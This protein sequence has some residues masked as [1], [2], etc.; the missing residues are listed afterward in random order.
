V[1]AFRVALP[2][3]DQLGVLL[4]LN[5]LY[6]FFSC[7]NNMFSVLIGHTYSCHAIALFISFNFKERLF[8]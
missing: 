1:P 5:L 3:H 4:G 8:S 6:S 7:I 2:E